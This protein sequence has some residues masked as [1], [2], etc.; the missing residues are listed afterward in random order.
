MSRRRPHRI[1]CCS[2][3]CFEAAAF[4][5]GFRL[6]ARERASGSAPAPALP[7]PCAGRCPPPSS[8]RPRPVRRHFYGKL[9]ERQPESAVLPVYR[10]RQSRR[11]LRRKQYIITNRRTHAPVYGGG[12]QKD[13]PAPA[14]VGPALRLTY[15]KSNIF[16]TP[17]SIAI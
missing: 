3:S 7:A 10:P 4:C 9:K 5:G 6:C 12:I 15:S 11:T 1:I 13:F 16:P 2:T 8:G 14:A 17:K